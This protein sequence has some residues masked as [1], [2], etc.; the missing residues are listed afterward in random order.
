MQ[1]KGLSVSTLVSKV[2]LSDVT[3]C[4]KAWMKLSGRR[5]VVAKFLVRSRH[6]IKRRLW[7]GRVVIRG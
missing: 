3:A 7:L 2:E 5:K 4:C 1:G 6:K